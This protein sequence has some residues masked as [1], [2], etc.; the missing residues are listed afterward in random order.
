MLS[1]D[2]WFAVECSFLTVKNIMLM[3]SKRKLPIKLNI[4][5]VIA[6]LQ[7][8]SQ[9]AADY[10]NSKIVGVNFVAKP[11]SSLLDKM[12]YR[13]KDI[14][15]MVRCKIKGTQFDATVERL[16]AQGFHLF[17]DDPKSTVLKLLQCSPQ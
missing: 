13:Q 12:L 3:M 4:V 11:L 8:T 2:L 5:Q 17:E 1:L 14:H 9:V 6:V 7:K 16:K 15:D 10:L